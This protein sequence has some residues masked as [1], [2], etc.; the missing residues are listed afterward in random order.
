MSAAEILALNPRG[1]IMTADEYVPDVTGFLG[2]DVKVTA[3]DGPNGRFWIAFAAV[4][5][6]GGNDYFYEDERAR[7]CFWAEFYYGQMPTHWDVKG[8]TRQL[9]GGGLFTSSAENAAVF[10]SN[11]EFFFKTRRWT[12]PAR[13]GDASSAQV[14]VSFSWSVAP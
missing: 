3:I 13:P 2:P 5:R 8:A 11:I 12:D 4:R 10:R 9:Q 6:G 14:P 7:F 1:K